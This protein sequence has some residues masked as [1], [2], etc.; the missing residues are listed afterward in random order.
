VFREHVPTL[1]A[2]EDVFARAMF[3]VTAMMMPPSLAISDMTMPARFTVTLSG[4]V[5]TAAA[6]EHHGSNGL[7]RLD[8]RIAATPFLSV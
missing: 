7:F 1:S 2:S 3:D 4:F 8:R 5:A 6:G